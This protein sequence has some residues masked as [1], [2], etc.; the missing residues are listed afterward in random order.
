M[1]PATKRTKS[2]FLKYREFIGE[3]IA[4]VQ[5]CI[6]AM[7][8][9]IHSHRLQLFREGDHCLVFNAVICVP[10]MAMPYEQVERRTNSGYLL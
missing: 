4:C 6:R 7:K 10:S 2:V 8:V 5:A 9:N 1:L 3:P